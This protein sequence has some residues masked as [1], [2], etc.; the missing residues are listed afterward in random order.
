MR[1]YC[2]ASMSQLTLELSELTLLI[3]KAVTLTGD[4][5]NEADRL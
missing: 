5:L 2:A 4:F 1:T 3:T